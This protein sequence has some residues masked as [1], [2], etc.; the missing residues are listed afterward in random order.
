MKKLTEIARTLRPEGTYRYRVIIL[1]FLAAA[2]FWF[3]N[4]LNEDY[5]ANVRYPLEFIYDA[6]KYVAVDELPED[7]QLNV[8]GLGWNLLR[9]NLGIKV[10]PVQI[11]LDNPVEVKK[12]SGSAMPAFL[13]DQLNEFNLNFV[14]TDTLN[15]SIDKR[16]DRL[17]YVHIDSSSIDL[18]E[19]YRLTSSIAV[20]PD[21]LRISGPST[22]LAELSDTV[23][24]KLPQ[25]N[26]DENYEEM[27]PITLNHPKSKLLSRSPTTINV[28]FNVEEF[29]YIDSEINISLKNFPAGSALE[30][31][32]I[33][34]KY[35]IPADNE[36]E[37]DLNEFEIIADFRNVS[38]V[39]S[40]ITLSLEGIPNLV[41]EATLD[42]ATF[43]VV[44]DNE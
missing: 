27:I 24:I 21:T 14:I 11:P 26:I 5:S 3:F 43:K 12:I 8:S 30:P 1:C 36:D 17:F 28:E 37:V 16:D 6:D 20:S 4:A 13:V 22:I 38:S 33:T 23:S 34:V 40:T 29:T 44:Y 18:E 10:T 9:N 7:I 25:N 2:T 31:D 32:V 15:I 41:S 42:S 35:L 19:G 39:D